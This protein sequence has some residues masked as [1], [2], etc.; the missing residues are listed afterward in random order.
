MLKEYD[1]EVKIGVASIGTVTI[2]AYNRDEAIK[3]FEREFGYILKRINDTYDQ[4]PS[5]V[6]LP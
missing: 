3:T 5:L 1:I 2:E 4:D 6:I